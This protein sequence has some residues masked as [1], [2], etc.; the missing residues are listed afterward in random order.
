M[1]TLSNIA[2]TI[3]LNLGPFMIIFTAYPFKFCLM[4]STW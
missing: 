2:M 3:S 4:F 1:I